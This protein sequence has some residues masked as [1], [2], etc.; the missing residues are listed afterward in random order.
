[1]AITRPGASEDTRRLGE[2][3]LSVNARHE[4]LIDGLLTLADSE[5]AV[6]ERSRVDLADVAGHVARA[7]A[8]MEADVEIDTD[9]R[10]APTTG[11]PVLLERVV[12][13]LVENAVRH[14]V[15]GGRVGV[16]TAT[17]GDT[18]ELTVTNT[19]PV[20]PPYE[21][22]TIFRPFRRLSGE[23]AS[24]DRG[25]GLGLSIVAAVAQAHGGRVTAT[26]REGGGLTVTVALPAAG[27]EVTQ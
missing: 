23:R 3:L 16:A 13:N 14:N 1:V 19:G 27:E 5:H 17:R 25:F 2:S 18:A 6:G 9:L 11:D 26:P 15:P 12:Q 10:A 8:G 24:A 20:V 22:E 4:R 7:T 21:V